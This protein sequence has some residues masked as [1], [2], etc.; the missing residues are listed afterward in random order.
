MEKSIVVC[1]K[2]ITIISG[3]LQFT[4]SFLFESDNVTV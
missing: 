2:S 3:M 4:E 1:N